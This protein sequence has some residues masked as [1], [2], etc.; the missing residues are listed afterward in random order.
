MSKLGL[1]STAARLGVSIQLP[2]ALFSVD[3]KIALP[4]GV[5]WDTNFERKAKHVSC[6][7]L[8]VVIDLILDSMCWWW[9]HV[10]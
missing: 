4:F 10:F 2:S 6:Q 1:D 8:L 9:V 5:F 7:V 3:V